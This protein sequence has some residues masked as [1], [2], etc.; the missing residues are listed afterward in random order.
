[1]V[2]ILFMVQLV[3]KPVQAI[4]RRWWCKSL[5]RASRGQRRCRECTKA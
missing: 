3:R 5:C 2:D 1:M 4:A